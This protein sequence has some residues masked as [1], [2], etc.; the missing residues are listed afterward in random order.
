[1]VH[2]LPDSALFFSASNDRNTTAGVSRGIVISDGTFQ[3]NYQEFTKR[4]HA[5]CDGESTQAG[6]GEDPS[7]SE[8]FS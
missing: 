3:R 5:G 6:H 1:M 7:S 2:P 4:P 8:A